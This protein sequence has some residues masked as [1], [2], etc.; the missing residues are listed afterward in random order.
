MK[1]RGLR[2]GPNRTIGVVTLFGK[3]PSDEPKDYAVL[4]VACPRCKTD[5]RVHVA[6]GIGAQKSRER[7]PCLNR[8]DRFEVAV[9]RI[10]L[11]MTCGL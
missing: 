9:T 3:T 5:Q 2:H 8:D 11:F 7:V 6:A 1:V 4:T 10:H